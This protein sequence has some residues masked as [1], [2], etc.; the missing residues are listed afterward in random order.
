MRQM[1]AAVRSGHDPVGKLPEAAIHR[2][3]DLQI[4]CPKCDVSYNLVCDF[5]WAVSRRFEEESRRMIQ[6][7]KKAVFE[8]H[9]D[10]HWVVH[11]ETSGV[12]VKRFGEPPV[13]KREKP[14][15]IM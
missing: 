5:D 3:L 1:M 7:L 4:V 8:G 10:G 13:K 12:V 2:W 9:G 14:L 11:F 15:P 6:M